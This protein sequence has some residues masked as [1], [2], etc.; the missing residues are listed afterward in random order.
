MQDDGK[1]ASKMR[2]E[3]SGVI[4]SVIPYNYNAEFERDFCL[5]LYNI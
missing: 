2:A 5:I 4:Y 1:Y 3:P